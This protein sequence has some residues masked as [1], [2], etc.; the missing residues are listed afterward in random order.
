M[1]M[2]EGPIL[3]E[4]RTIYRE[5]AAEVES[6]S[7]ACVASGRC[8]RFKEYGH[9]L[10]VTDL[11]LDELFRLHGPPAEVPSD[12]CPYQIG[13]LCGAR[14]GR[15]LACR[16]FFCDPRWQERMGA[17]AERLHGRLKELHQRHQVRY[18][19]G[20]LLAMLR[21]RAESSQATA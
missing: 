16:L 4:L 18:R 6:F 7:P 5:V 12:R 20:E 19:Y 21:A 1:A 9:D 11:E 3:E 15:P 8:C 17:L 13:L 14:M 10:F 2:V